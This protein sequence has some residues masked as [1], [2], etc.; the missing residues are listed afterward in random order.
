MPSMDY[1]GNAEARMLATASK[2]KLQRVRGAVAKLE[3]LEP[4]TL[5]RNYERE[6]VRAEEEVTKA[7]HDLTSELEKLDGG[8]LLERTRAEWFEAGGM[9]DYVRRHGELYP[10]LPSVE[11][12]Q[13]DARSEWMKVQ[14]SK[15]RLRG[16]KE[17]LATLQ[18]AFYALLELGFQQPADMAEVVAQQ[19]SMWQGEEA[20]T[21]EVVQAQKHALGR[22]REQ[23]Q[24]WHRQ[25]GELKAAERFGEIAQGADALALRAMRL[26][27]ME[28]DA[29]HLRAR[30][31]ATLRALEHAKEAHT[32]AKCAT[33]P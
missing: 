13:E 12:E 33:P 7:H 5:S 24:A 27:I 30:S 20:R 10:Y 19:R 6:L 14:P 4:S 16:A 8:D 31:K 23:R 9:T 32:Q 11:G 18:G 26:S 17:R 15:E 22:R 21:S 2:R 3:A 25:Q 29:Q 28:R 1:P